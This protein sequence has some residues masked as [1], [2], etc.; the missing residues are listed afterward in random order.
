MNALIKKRVSYAVALALPI[1]IGIPYIVTVRFDDDNIHLQPGQNDR[2]QALLV[3]EVERI[4]EESAGQK[5][6]IEVQAIPSTRPLN[7]SEKVVASEDKPLDSKYSYVKHF[8]EMQVRSMPQADQ[9]ELPYQDAPAWLNQQK[10]ERELRRLARNAN[11]NW[12]FGWVLA[13]PNFDVEGLQAQLESS[14]A[15]VL[16]TSGRMVRVKF[17]ID[18]DRLEK[19]SMLSNVERIGYTPRE[20]KMAAFA[21]R[22]DGV[23]GDV[24]PIYVTLMVGDDDGRWRHEMTRI[25]AVVG[26]YHHELRVYRVN[27]TRAVIDTLAEADFVQAIEPIRVIEATHDTAVPAMGLGGLRQFDSSMRRFVGN[28]GVSIPIGVM[29]SGLNVNHIDIASNRSSICGANFALHLDEE[30][31]GRKFDA[32]D[33][34]WIDLR[35]HGT[36]VTGSIL[37][38]GAQTRRFAGVAPGIQ[39]IRI[40]KVLDA[41]GIGVTGVTLDAM[42]FMARE[43]SCDSSMESLN[44]VAPLIVNMSLSA[45]HFSFQGRDVPARALD[46]TVWS[47]GQLYVVAQ[48]NKST[49]SFS[50]YAA[51]KNSLAVGA[52][53]D[54]GKVATFSSHGPTADGRLIPNVVGIGVRVHSPAGAGQRGGYRAENGTSSAS[55]LVAGVAAVLLDTVPDFRGFPALTRAQLMVTA[56]RPEWWLT[57]TSDFTT[58]NTSGPGKIQAQYGLGKVSARASILNHD[59]ATGW[60]SGSASASLADGEYAYFDI[61]VPSDA[62]GL[63]VVMTWDE[64]AGDAVVSTVIN[65]LDLWLDE[66]GDC[67]GIACGEHSSRSKIDNVEWIFVS[68]P[69]PGIHRIKVLA[70]AVYTGEPRAAIAW[71]VIRGKSTPIL[72][73]DVD[74][75]HIEGSGDH[76]LTLS[77][78]SDSYVAAGVTLHLDCRTVEDGECG[79]VL[80]IEDAVFIGENGLRASLRDEF[81]LTLPPE[82]ELKPA[83]KIPSLLGSSLPMGE[84]AAG[85]EQKIAIR[86]SIASTVEEPNLR[87]IFKASAW[88]A[89]ADTTSVT[90]GSAEDAIAERPVNDDFATA[91]EISGVSGV[92]SLDFFDATPEPGEPDVEPSLERAAGSV[93]YTWQAPETDRFRFHVP[94]LNSDA[95]TLRLDYVHIFQG[96]R[97]SSLTP[98]ASGLWRAS[99]RAQRGETYRIRISGLTRSI[100][101]NLAWDLAKRPENDDFVNAQSLGG[102]SFSVTGSTIGATLEAD[103]FLG[104]PAASTWY[105]WTAPNDS[106]WVFEAPG[107]RVLAFTGGSIASLR[108]VSDTPTAHA[109]FPTRAGQEYKVMVAEVEAGS[110]GNQFQLRWFQAT[111]SGN[112]SFS[113]AEVVSD[114]KTQRFRVDIDYYAT[115][116]PDEPLAT[117]VRTRWWVW[118]APDTGRYTWRLTNTETD[119]PSFQDLTVTVFTGNQLTDLELIA[120]SGPGAPYAFAFD[121]NEGERFWFAVGLPSDY[122]SAY[123]PARPNGWLE[124]QKSP[125]NDLA[126]NAILLSGLSG[127]LKGNNTFATNEVGERILG[128]GRGTLWWEYMA[129]TSGWIR[130]TVAG[131]GGPWSLAVVD[132]HSGGIDAS[133]IIAKN[134][135]QRSE[136]DVLFEADEGV[137]Y[138]I[139]LGSANVGYG[140]EFTLTWNEADEPGWIRYV[141][142]LTD[143]HLDSADTEVAIRRP[144]ELAMNG[145]GTTLYLASSVGLSV[146]DRDIEHGELTLRQ[147]VDT[148]IDLTRASIVWDSKSSRLLAEECG[149]WYS[150]TSA[151]DATA[152]VQLRAIDVADDPGRCALFLLMDSAGANLYR[153]SRQHIQQ[154]SVTDSGNI[155]FENEL[156][157]PQPIRSAILAADGLHMY[158]VTD[159]LLMLVRNAESN[160]LELT[161]YEDSLDIDA[162][163]GNR[164]LPI[165]LSEDGGHLFAFDQL[166]QSGHVYLLRDDRDPA[167]IGTLEPFWSVLDASHSNRCRYAD[168]YGKP[169]HIEVFCPSLVFAARWNPLE[170]RLTG[171]DYISR[172]QGDRFNSFPLPNFDI[173]KGIAVS[174][175]EKYVYLVTPHAGILVFKRSLLSEQVNDT[176]RQAF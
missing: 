176:V 95:S 56:I 160:L 67:E 15:E 54:S 48:G 93:W 45:R 43:T 108:L 14:G 153:V 27:A 34:L 117:G 127:E 140:G 114:L 70:D 170:E 133:S 172:T 20:T 29:D 81:F 40:A 168:T 38:N 162:S 123:K 52:I 72:N 97:V 121:A 150:S 85:D 138:K 139:V 158:I 39:H 17:A 13:A 11:R 148:E 132:E 164:A 3:N 137:N 66:K 24:L 41:E 16:G 26:R 143:G 25:G 107:Q 91:I 62:S 144:G 105:R 87:L 90:V 53:R 73:I 7:E 63:D 89:H 166:G 28:T 75:N 102:D 64:P 57:G 35:G 161:E 94:S 10:P 155:V 109:D 88:N 23:S 169:T 118:D 98:I 112:D 31:V 92:V 119:S 55:P 49:E 135:W 100:G 99:F 104:V 131:D 145:D 47:T 4:V 173:P 129:P 65:D 134:Q 159:R 1:C 115:V 6:T 96:N 8:G 36:H 147:L 12:S 124:W 113:E 136:N 46:T 44:H 152:K 106:R 60:F 103:E 5:G 9:R 151:D 146:F 32:D 19:I 120:K 167:K 125:A 21:G 171:I 174:P 22:L 157:L 128:I 76:E 86:L 116:E 156:S 163:L 80:A 111:H 50:N 142:Q 37:G 110:D 84:I 59:V 141:G 79:D 77:L 82:Y 154:F 149:N 165:A 18:G 78:T 33:D 68:N 122:P 30:G 126:V 61:E 2:Y 83:S 42:R 51:A 69:E 71:K 175:D 130:F 74:Q 101:M 58:D